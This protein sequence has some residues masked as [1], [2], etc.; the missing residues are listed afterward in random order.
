MEASLPGD[1]ED[2]ELLGIILEEV[3]RL[4][5]VV[6]SFLDY[7]R[8][9][10]GDSVPVDLND[11][12]TRTLALAQRDLPAE[13]RLDVSLSQSLPMVR[14]DPNI[15]VKS[16]SI[17]Y[18]TPWKPWK[19]M[20]SSRL[21]PNRG[22]AFQAWSSSWCGTT[23]RASRAKIFPIFSC[24]FSQRKPQAPVSGLQSASVW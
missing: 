1:T 3:G 12:V 14:I 6:G 18:A 9:Y 4:N 8:P 21:R 2:R 24:R 16:C 13:L 15:S 11:A 7:A 22:W 19:A 17:S 10:R 20:G 23:D 5:R